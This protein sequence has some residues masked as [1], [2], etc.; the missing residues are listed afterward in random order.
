ME[1]DHIAQ[2][3][4]NLIARYE[5]GEQKSGALCVGPRPECDISHIRVCLYTSLARKTDEPHGDIGDDP[6]ISCQVGRM[7]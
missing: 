7:I 1:T 5:R 4:E 2:E 3:L 6:E